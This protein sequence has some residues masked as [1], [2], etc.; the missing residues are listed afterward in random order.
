MRQ[1]HR[2][3][4]RQEMGREDFELQ[5]K[6]DKYL[7]DVELHHHDF[8]EIYFL[9]SGDVTY[10]IE[11]RQYHVMPGDLLLISPQELHQICVRPEMSDY[12]RF[13]LWV[14]PQLLS[15]IS[16]PL[17]DLAKHLGSSGPNRGNLLRLK[18][19]DTSHVLKLF[20]QLWQESESDNYGSDLLRQSL[21]IQLL[22][23]INRFATNPS[24]HLEE[25]AHSSRAISEVVDYVNLHYSEPLSLDMLAELVYVSK[26]HLSHEFNRQ[27]GTSVYRYIQ[28]KRL[29][30]A[31]HLLAQGKKPNE[32]YSN[33]GFSDYAGFY[34]AFRAEY[35]ISP[36][37][38]AR[39]VRP[40]S[41]DSTDES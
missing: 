26:Y 10:T 14:D 18:P 15:R 39:S 16:T 2:F 1:A 41:S 7:Q 34:R 11:S 33:C 38:Y 3:D 30:I 4:P 9:I 5:Y 12:E 40:L 31:R 32:V 27:V 8:H 24:G 35:A 21:L 19:E 6:K 13:V 28:K 29:L 22:V 37:E 25:I 36:R 20:E 23:T 17:S